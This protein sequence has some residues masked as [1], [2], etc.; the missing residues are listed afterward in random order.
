MM[1]LFIVILK[2]FELS[3]LGQN[4][5]PT[6]VYFIENGISLEIHKSGFIQGSG[7]TINVMRMKNLLIRPSTK[8][9]RV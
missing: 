9:G 1:K 5:G 8:C 7:G 4:R 3:V 2:R 6:N